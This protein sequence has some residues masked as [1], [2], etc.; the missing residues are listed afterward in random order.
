LDRQETKKAAGFSKL[1][2]KTAADHIKRKPSVDR[3]EWSRC[4][5]SGSLACFCTSRFAD[6][7][8]RG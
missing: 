5:K 7:G 4:E 1:R 8:Q 3:D 6:F 2:E